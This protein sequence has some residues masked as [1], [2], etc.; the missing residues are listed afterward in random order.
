[1]ETAVKHATKTPHSDMADPQL[2]SEFVMKTITALRIFVNDELNQL[3]F[4]IRYLATKYL[5]IDGILAVIA[6]NNAEKKVV[7]RCL[8]QISLDDLEDQNEMLSTQV[9]LC[10]VSYIDPRN[11]NIA[12]DN[13]EM[14]LSYEEIEE[15]QNQN[16][17]K[18]IKGEPIP[19][20]MA[21]QI[22]YP[23]FKNAVL[24]AAQRV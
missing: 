18:M 4:A 14:G 6:H 22:L 5:K 11:I 9:I 24:F 16:P 3:D 2:V 12:K 13:N 20:P 8:K 23:R 17:W 21:E 19:L 1:M 15:I 7:Q 10:R